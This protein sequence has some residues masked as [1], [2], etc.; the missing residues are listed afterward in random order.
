MS[1]WPA[2]RMKFLAGINERALPEDTDPGFEF[3]YVDITTVGRGN[4]AGE[5]ERMRFEGAPSR[6][7]RLVQAGDT[8][9]STVRTYLRAVWPVR[10]PTHDLVVSTG[11]AVISPKK[12][13][14]PRYLGWWAQSDPF[15]EEIVARSVGVSYPAINASEIGDLRM[16]LPPLPVQ[17]AIADYLDAETARIDAL[18]AKKRRMIELLEERLAAFIDSALRF[19]TDERVRLGRV[20]TSLTQGWSPQAENRPAESHEFGL[21][22]LNAVKAGRYVPQENKAMPD[23]LDVGP[24]LVPQVGD[25]LVTRANTPLLVGDVCSVREFAP[26][27]VLC[28]LIYRLRLDAR[29]IPEYAAYALRTSEARMH[30][31]SAARG[32]S[33]SMVKLRGEDVKA[34][35]VPALSLA[36]QERLVLLFD[37]E[38]AKTERTAAA[39][40]TQLDLLAEHRQALIT[41]AVTGELDVPGVPA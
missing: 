36:D 15:V 10:G 33:Q 14:N 9:V 27:A 38:R 41:A 30:L 32:T 24:D 7:R 37:A 40:L 26:K 19:A 22:K 11:F 25:L 3:R 34:T 1:A 17:R 6:A 29:M 12:R 21:L 16:P 8:I 31:S 39:H 23:D 20:V 18:I 4:L 35:P 28:D 5:P 13:L 2:E